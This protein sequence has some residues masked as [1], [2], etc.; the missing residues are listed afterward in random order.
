ME[1][2]ITY[3]RFVSQPDD[4]SVMPFLSTGT[5]IDSRKARVLLLEVLLTLDHFDIDA[6]ALED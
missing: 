4:P 2:S 5:S 3:L 1:C 6:R